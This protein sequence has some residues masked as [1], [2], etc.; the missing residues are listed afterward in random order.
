MPGE[1]SEQVPVVLADGDI[2]GTLGS[3][4]G[5]ELGDAA[6]EASLRVPHTTQVECPQK[7]F[8]FFRRRD[9]PIIQPDLSDVQPAWFSWNH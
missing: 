8:W 9:A 6:Q 4:E 1:G 2:L 7:I 5:E 3:V